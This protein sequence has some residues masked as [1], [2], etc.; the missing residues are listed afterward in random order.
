MRGMVTRIPAA[1]SG[2]RRLAFIAIAILAGVVVAFTAL[3]GFLVDVLWFREVG[4]S[5]VFWKVFQTKVVLGLVFGIAFFVLLYVNL[6]IVRRVTPRYRA[7]TPE[8]ESVEDRKSTRL[9][10]SH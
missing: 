4:Y 8:Q 5:Q 10:S 3:S 7:M 1:S 2:R 6:W 9:N